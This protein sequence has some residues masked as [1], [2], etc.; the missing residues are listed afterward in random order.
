M[1]LLSDREEANA[2]AV[3]EAV[4]ETLI[5]K[6]FASTVN[7]SAR[8]ILHFIEQMITGSIAEISGES[9]KGIIG[10]S[11]RGSNKD[12]SSKGGLQSIV[13]SIMKRL[14]PNRDGSSRIYCLQKLVEVADYNMDVRPRLVWT[15]IWEMMAAHFADVCSG[16]NAMLSMFAVDSLR[17]LS[18]KFLEIPEL[19][20]FNFQR[21]FLRPFEQI[22]K[23]PN[24]RVDIRELVLRCVDNMIRSLSDNLRSGYVHFLLQLYFSVNYVI[25]S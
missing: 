14:R 21:V 7:L 23:N 17:Q 1:Q 19:N 6:V 5:D 25:I 2:R 24:S 9:M 10:V 18:F 15:Q 4:N 16:Q 13:P 11:H 22:M 20:D 8:G 3:L 12:N